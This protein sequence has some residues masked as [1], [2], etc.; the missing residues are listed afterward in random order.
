MNPTAN[1]LI[2]FDGEF[3]EMGAVQASSTPPAPA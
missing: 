1:G 3:L 2:D